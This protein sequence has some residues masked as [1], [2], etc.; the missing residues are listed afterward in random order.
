MSRCFEKRENYISDKGRMTCL[1]DV[2]WGRENPKVIS[3]QETSRNG[4]KLSASSHLFQFGNPWEIMKKK[5]Y[6]DENVTQLSHLKKKEVR[7]AES[8][9][10]RLSCALIYLYGPLAFRRGWGTVYNIL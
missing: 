7:E 10:C 6:S 4:Y 1:S 2:Y 5:I 9:I 8:C 3:L